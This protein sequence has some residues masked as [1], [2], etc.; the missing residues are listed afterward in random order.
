MPWGSQAE[1]RE[2]ISWVSKPSLWFGSRNSKSRHPPTGECQWLSVTLHISWNWSRLQKNSC[3][4]SWGDFTG[5]TKTF[6]YRLDLKLSI[7]LVRD[8]ALSK[9]FT[10]QINKM[11]E[12][13]KK[14]KKMFHFASCLQIVQSTSVGL[15]ILCLSIYWPF[16][17]LNLWI[18][19][20][21]GQCCRQ[22]SFPPLGGSLIR[23]HSH[24]KNSK[25]L[26]TY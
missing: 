26:V 22:Q 14:K 8:T 4:L 5:K 2:S 18:L 15:D 9:R 11:F 10:E 20:L 13:D 19:W 6:S 24:E 7:K 17:F 3:T 16:L 1:Q 25:G 23:T 21:K 12:W